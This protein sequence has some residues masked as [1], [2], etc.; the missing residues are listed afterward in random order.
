MK[1]RGSQSE[2]LSG[3][4]QSWVTVSPSRI[5]QDAQRFWR[6]NSSW[7]TIAYPEFEYGA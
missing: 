4:S 2:D 6:E 3:T 1:H 7:T 5:M